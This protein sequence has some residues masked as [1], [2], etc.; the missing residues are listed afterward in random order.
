MSRSYRDVKRQLDW[1]RVQ[2]YTP[3][4]KETREDYRKR[5]LD[6]D[7]NEMDALEIM[8]ALFDGQHQEKH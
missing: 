7:R 2:E 5:R 4:G 8:Q 1:S 3:R 6:E